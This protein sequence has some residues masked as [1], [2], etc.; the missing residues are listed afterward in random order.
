[1]TSPNLKV[2]IAS[3]DIRVCYVLQ[4]ILDTHTHACKIMLNYCDITGK[5]CLCLMWIVGYLKSRCAKCVRKAKWQ[6]PFWRRGTRYFVDWLFLLFQFHAIYDMLRD[7]KIYFI[8]LPS[9]SS[10][11]YK[12]DVVHPTFIFPQ[13]TIRVGQKHVS[14]SFVR[15]PGADLLPLQR[16]MTK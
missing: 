5:I 4:Y 2:K 13:Y 3:S 15:F 12:L 8:A 9:P 14:A 1:M 7:L 16:K 10:G 11:V 6:V